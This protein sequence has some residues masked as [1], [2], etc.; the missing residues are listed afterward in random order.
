[1]K[2]KLFMFFL[3]FVVCGA[4]LNAQSLDEAILGAAAKISRDL[5]SGSTAAVINF[6]SSSEALNNYVL[7]ELYGAIYRNRRIAPV[8][9]DQKQFQ[10][11]RNKLGIT[12]KPDIESA[13]S[14][15][16]LLEVQYLVTGSL[17]KTGAGYSIA[18]NAVDT[19]AVLKSNYQAVLKQND[20][21]LVSLLGS[22]SQAS[23]AL[24]QKPVNISAIAGVQAP[25]TGRTP[26]TTITENAQYSGTV[27]WSPM[28]SGVFKTSTQYTAT[29]TLKAKTGWS[30]QEVTADFWTVAGAE[31]VHNNAGSGVVTAV[32]PATSDVI[33]NI[34]AIAGVTAPVAGKAPVATITETAQYK[35]TVAWS[36]A[37][38][39]TFKSFTKYTATITI[40]A[41]SGYTL[42]G[43]R[44]NFFTVAGAVSTGNDANSCVITAAFPPTSEKKVVYP[45]DEKLWSLGA[46]AGT[47]FAAPLFIGT[48]HGTLAPFSYSFL[49][50]G[51]DAGLGIQLDDVKYFSLYPYANYALFLPFA[52]TSNARGNGWYAGAGLGVMFANY[53]FDPEGPVWETTFA[54][55]FITG[56]NILDMF[57]I[58]YTLRTNFKSV[59]SKLSLGYVYRF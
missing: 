28:V 57:D 22:Q 45:E 20:A 13:Q 8:L 11:I 29:I 10:T 33:I 31:S 41:K 34:A 44:A 52:R 43:V 59:S 56:F 38:S 48:I 27:T 30:L 36:P 42:E 54:V 18:F 9:P 12:G 21:Q 39:G 51:V 53:T 58:S 4:F 35:G 17:E 32:F 3:G 37:V 1:M 14:I 46:S 15:A 40:T 6:R 50:L 16:Q 7:N 26:V 23:A 47:S 19:D 55:N 49:E 25:V 2:H 5:P 24:E